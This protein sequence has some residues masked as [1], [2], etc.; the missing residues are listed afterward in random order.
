M[1]GITGKGEEESCIHLRWKHRDLRPQALD[2]VPEPVQKIRGYDCTRLRSLL[3]PVGAAPLT[4][5]TARSPSPSAEP[6]L[7]LWER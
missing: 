7:F 5:S 4:S 3:P 2:P 1:D 6:Y